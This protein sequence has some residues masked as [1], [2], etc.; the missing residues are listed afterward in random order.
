[1]TE[2]KNSLGV[3]YWEPAWIPVKAS[4]YEEYS[5]KWET[6]G[7]GWSSSYAQSYDSEHYSAGGCVMDNQ[8]LFNP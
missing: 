8:A 5:Y 2:T 3:F 7:S 1:M 4:N 6:Y